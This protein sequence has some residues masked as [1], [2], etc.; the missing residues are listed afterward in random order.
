MPW[1]LKYNHLPEERWAFIENIFTKEE[2]GEIINLGKQKSLEEAF[3]SNNVSD[4]SVRVTNV[5]W[6]KTEK[7]ELPKYE[8]IYRRCTDA[9]NLI[10]EKYFK[11]DLTFI[12]ELQFTAYDKK[13]SFYGKHIDAEYD[14]LGYRKLSF[15]IQL[16]EEKSYKGGSLCMYNGRNPDFASR[17]IGTFVA[18]PSWLLHEVT[19]IIEGERYSLVGWVHGPRFK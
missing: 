12:E 5:S 3:I 1:F 7:E 11:Y 2:C 4:D 9:V 18:F 8:W 16:S 14:G 15:T 13:G 10:N 19:P 6:F 17:E